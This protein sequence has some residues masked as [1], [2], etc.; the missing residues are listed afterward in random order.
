MLSFDPS[1]ADRIGFVGDTHANRGWMRR[2]LDDLAEREVT[3]VVVLGDFGYWP[4]DRQGRAFLTETADCARER[5]IQLAFLDGNHEDHRELAKL[6]LTDHRQHALTDHLTYLGRGARLRFVEQTLVV[7]GGAVSVDRDLRVAGRSW[8]A[9]EELTDEQVEWI[10]ADGPADVLLAHD[11]PFGVRTLVDSYQQV[12]PASQRATPWPT[13]VLI[14][15]DEHQRRISRLV[16]GLGVRTV[17]HGHHHRR[18]DD[19]LEAAGTEVSVHGLDCDGTA[20]GAGWVI[21]DGTDLA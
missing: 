9:T 4:R 7:A 8:F 19:V 12:K 16:E 15:A 13:S 10:I 6:P 11:A 18:F 1:T 5:G 21:W 20:R 14:A 2:V 17:F 3:H